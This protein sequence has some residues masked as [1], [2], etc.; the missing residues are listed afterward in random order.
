MRKIK[1]IHDY[2]ITH[3]QYDT[4]MNQGV[5]APYFALT[6]GKTL[7]QGYAMLF[8]QMAKEENIPVR[9]ISGTAGSKKIG[10]AWNLVQV[11]GVWYHL[12]AT[13]DDPIPDVAGRTV[14]TYLSSFK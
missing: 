7:C 13:W 8:Y 10:H 12:D 6:Q 3:V 14:Y 2:I 5:N 11:D 9:L 1:A 4:T